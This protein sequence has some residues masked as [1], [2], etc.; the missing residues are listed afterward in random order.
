MEKL[1]LGEISS[2]DKPDKSDGDK[3]GARKDEDKKAPSKGFTSAKQDKWPG[4]SDEEL[5]LQCERELEEKLTQLKEKRLKSEDLAPASSV[6]YVVDGDKRL[7][8]G[9]K[10]ELCFKN[11]EAGFFREKKSS[12]ITGIEFLSLSVKCSILQNWYSA[13]PSHVI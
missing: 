6:K 1:L 8:S 2:K 3:K 7:L 13:F 10:A 11:G 9:D 5:T 4:M 12:G